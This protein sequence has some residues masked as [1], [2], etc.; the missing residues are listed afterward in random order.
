MKILFSLIVVT[1]VL[2]GLNLYRLSATDS[3]ATLQPPVAQ[4]TPQLPALQPEQQL[5]LLEQ[6]SAANSACNG[7]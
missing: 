7:A 1:L 4:T 3:D 5:P 6:S 2:F